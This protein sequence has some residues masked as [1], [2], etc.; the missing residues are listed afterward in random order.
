VKPQAES[1]GET[2]VHTYQ[3]HHILKSP[4]DGFK[5]HEYTNVKDAEFLNLHSGVEKL[6]SKAQCH[7]NILKI[8]HRMVVVALSSRIY[9]GNHALGSW[10]GHMADLNVI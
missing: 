10:V 1:S 6:E 5:S 9:L 8:W 7:Q 4:R 3:K 2:L